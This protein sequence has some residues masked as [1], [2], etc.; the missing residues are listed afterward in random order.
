MYDETGTRIARTF[1]GADGDNTIVVA[2]PA[3]GPHVFIGAVAKEWGLG[4]NPVVHSELTPIRGKRLRG[5][6]SGRFCVGDEKVLRLRVRPRAPDPLPLPEP[7]ADLV[8]TVA[9]PVP[10]VEIPDV[11]E[12]S[13]PTPSSTASVHVDVTV[14]LAAPPSPSAPPVP[15]SADV[16]MNSPSDMELDS[17]MGGDVLNVAFSLS[18]LSSVTNSDEEDNVA[19]EGESETAGED[20]GR[21]HAKGE[22]GHWISL[23][24]AD[25]AALQKCHQTKGMADRCEAVTLTDGDA[26]KAISCALGQLGI[27]TVMATEPSVPLP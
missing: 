7:A 26:A 27:P 6:G 4:S 24:A 17:E 9:D 13:I 3:R 2:Q 22:S 25:D 14:P 18:P 1:L 15:V 10:A 11:T 20:D 5:R 23:P 21:G 8:P 12:P 19:G 16:E